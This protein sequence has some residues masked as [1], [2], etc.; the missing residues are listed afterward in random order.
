[1]FPAQKTL[2]LTLVAAS[3]LTRPANSGEFQAGVAVVDVTP[4]TLPVL[5]NGGMTSRS[6]STVRTS[7]NARAFFFSDGDEQ[8]A[9]VVVDSCMIGRALL[10]DIKALAQQ[11]LGVPADRILISATHSHTAPASMGCLGTDADP[12]Y[13]PYLRVRIV[14]AIAAARNNLRPAEVGFGQ[15]AIPEMTALRR[16]VRRPDRVV[17]DPFGN[18]TVRANMHSGRVLDDVTGESGPEDPDLQIISLRTRDGAPLGLLAA[19]SMHYY[20]DRDISADYFGLFSDGLKS[21]LFPDSGFVAAMAHGCS[22]D[23]WRRDYMAPETWDPEQTIEQYADAMIDAAQKTLKDIKYRSDISLAMTETRLPLKYR[24]PDRQRLEWARRIVAEMG[25]RAP[26][27][28]PEV[29]AREQLLLHEAGQT[30][31]VVQGIRIGEI[32]IATTPTETYAITGLKIKSASPLQNT[33]VIELAN[34]GDGYIPPPEQH[35]LGGY[36]TWAARSAG[37]QMTAEPQITQAAIRMLEAVSGRPRR[38]DALPEGPAG[39]QIRK[40]SPLA[41][42]RM[43]DSSG[44]L[45]MDSSGNHRHGVLNAPVTYFLEGP[46]SDAYCGPDT[47]NRSLHFAGGRI[48]TVLPETGSQYTVAGW[49]WNGM[50]LDARP[51]A[52]WIYSRDHDYGVSVGGEHLGVLGGEEDSGRLIFRWGLAA[53]QQ[54]VGRRQ[55]ARWTWNH[56]ALVRDGEGYRI[57]L[58]GSQE[59]AG[60]ASECHI[61]RIFLGGRSDNSSNWEGRLDEFAVFSRALSAAE[62]EQIA[63]PQTT[64]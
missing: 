2:L 34:G 5:V 52:G 44:P 4:Q 59:M 8:L 20:G 55:I 13:V 62:I 61:D 49:I 46:L 24:I 7:V 1:M 54:A 57:Y 23:I 56:V 16:W 17:E 45:A 37:L 15:L 42:W 64:R 28:Q 63:K 38:S 50:P 40:L 39:A 32:G 53:Q 25:D 21:R 29:Y 51:I 27:T 30:E 6:I 3:V 48:T 14:E 43:N 47:M 58:N 18:L 19:F 31:V 35:L 11:K 9:I 33:M 36:N 12:N 41:W 26:K 10:D 22:G 60:N